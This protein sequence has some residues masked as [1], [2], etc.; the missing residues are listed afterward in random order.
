[1]FYLFWEEG[2]KMQTAVHGGDISRNQVQY[3]FSVNT[4]ALGFP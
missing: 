4:N 1:M 2:E 3:D